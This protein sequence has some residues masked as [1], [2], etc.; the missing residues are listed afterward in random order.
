MRAPRQPPQNVLGADDGEGERFQRAVKCGYEHHAAGAYQS[1]AGIEELIDVGHM[2]NDLH[3]EHDIEL[4]AGIGNAFNCGEPVID[5]EAHSLR[6]ISRDHNVPL[7][8]V[9]TRD[10]GPE[11]RHRLGQQST[12]AADICNSKPRE[13]ALI[14]GISIEIRTNSIANIGEAR[15]VE[16]VQRSEAALR[17][18]PFIGQCAEFCNF[19]IVDARFER[20]GLL[21]F[22]HLVVFPNLAPSRGYEYGYAALR[23]QPRPSD[24]QESV[25]GPSGAEIWWHIRR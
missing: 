1:A 13:R 10:L 11:P 12:A 23:R 3:A 17:I 9:K 19:V 20:L 4:F 16:L 25:Y 24:A 18:P 21:F 6:V 22:H 8:S 2:L 7:C 5:V 15:G 14:G